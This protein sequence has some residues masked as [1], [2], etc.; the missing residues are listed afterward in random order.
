MLIQKNAISE[1]TSNT[2]GLV[3]VFKQILKI[4]LLTLKPH[5]SWI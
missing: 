3:D 2:E 5:F 4:H 1:K